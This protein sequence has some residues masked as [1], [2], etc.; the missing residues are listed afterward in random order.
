MLLNKERLDISN[1]FY[2]NQVKQK[3]GNY[4]YGT[5]GTIFGLGYGPK[6]YQN[7]HGHFIDRFSNSEFT[8]HFVN[9]YLNVKILILHSNISYVPFFSS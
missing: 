5:S 2:I 1:K 9:T 3:Q 7:E 6:F 4:H 8:Y